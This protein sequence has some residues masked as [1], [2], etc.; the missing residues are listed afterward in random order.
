MAKIKIAIDAGHGSKTAG[1]RTPPFT[2]AVDIDKDGK[3]DVKKGESYHEH[4]ANVGIA[5]LLYHKLKANGYDVIKTGWDD[6]NA[7]NDDD[8]PLSNR[9]QT[10]KKNKCDYS[11]SI[12]FNAYGSGAAYN[13][14]AGVCIYIHSQYPKESRHLA[15]YVLQEL[16]KGTSQQNRGIHSDNLAM[17]NCKTMNTKAS[18]LCEI[19]FMT[20]ERE[21]QKLMANSD[22][23]EECATEIAKGIER[24]CNCNNKEEVNSKGVYTLTHTVVAGDTLSKLAK[25]YNTTVDK[26]VKLN[27]LKDPNKISVGQKLILMKYKL[28]TVKQG[29]TLSKISQQY[30][31]S[32]K[33]YP[34]IMELNMLADTLIHA[35]QILKIPVD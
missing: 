25:T 5:S 19:A 33:R 11:V 14:V 1:K 15:E 3:I 16:R 21:A 28:Y 22:F 29:D 2:Q 7:K 32:A 34:E 13:S 6:D 10:I 18:I 35:E 31:G 8:T 12:H 30:L 26:L 24:Y 27:K 4:Y 9:Q 20:N 17:C 23:W